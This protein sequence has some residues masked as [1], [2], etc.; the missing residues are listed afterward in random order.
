MS[1]RY[2]SRRRS[3]GAA[4]VEMALLLPILLALSAL[5]VDFGRL[6][7]QYNVLHKAVREAGRYLSSKL[8]G[9]DVL[10]PKQATGKSTTW[11]VAKYMV[12][13]YQS[14]L[15]CPA[16]GTCLTVTIEDSSNTASLLNVP[17][18]RGSYRLVRVTVSAYEMPT[19][20]LG[21]LMRLTGYS[22]IL[23]PSVSATFEQE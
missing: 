1:A 5:V 13:Q 3:S 2:P 10:D 16:S 15:N 9:P 22:K 14:S 12:Q 4:A 20:L 7:Y 18:G 11:E 19:L 8:P 21:P 17:F 23:L 6:T